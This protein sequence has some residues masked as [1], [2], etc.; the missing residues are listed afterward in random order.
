MG[1]KLIKYYNYVGESFGLEKKIELATL[2]K[3]PSPK[4]A[5]M[6]DTPAVIAEFKKAIEK[7]TGK[8][9]PDL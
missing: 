5:M 9:T 4:A 8:A 3:I 6:E 7:V 1:E 2:T